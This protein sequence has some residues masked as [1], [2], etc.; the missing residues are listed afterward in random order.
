[1]T[2]AA[3]PPESPDP[4][5]PA[6]RP[7]GAF[8]KKLPAILSIGGSFLGHGLL[9]YALMK[10]PRGEAVPEEPPLEI[11]IQVRRPPAP[12][13]VRQTPPKSAEEQKAEPAKD[14]APSATSPEAP[15]EDQLVAEEMVVDP[16]EPPEEVIPSEEPGSPG[17]GEVARS[18]AEG[19][20]GPPAVR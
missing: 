7:A 13:L 16:V 10:A 12:E 9:L 3:K 6:P 1:M 20:P 8:R 2:A 18:E 17:T 14:A 11:T 4:V 5:P 19:R 15:D